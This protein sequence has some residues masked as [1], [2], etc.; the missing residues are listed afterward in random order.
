[1]LRVANSHRPAKL[2]ASPDLYVAHSQGC[3]LCEQD[4]L[5]LTDAEIMARVTAKKPAAKLAKAVQH[6]QR[7]WLQVTYSRVI[8][9]CHTIWQQDV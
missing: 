7:T 2:L 5:E 1:M 4:L 8:A 3:I 9:A 6:L